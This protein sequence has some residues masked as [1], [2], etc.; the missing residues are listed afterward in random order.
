[1]PRAHVPDVLRGRVFRGRDAVAAGLLTPDALRS[2][3]WRRL[4]R[5][6]YADAE[7]PDTFGVRIRGA[8][9]VVPAAAV[10]SGRTAAY[11]HGATELVDVRTPVEVSIPADARF[12]PVAGL[13]VRRLVLTT[14]DVVVVRSRRCTTS[15]RTALDI[16]RAEPLVEG[17]AALDVLLSRGVVGHPQLRAAVTAQPTPR[18]AR[19]AEQ[20]VELA[21]VR[22]ESPQES[23]LRVVLTLAGLA[24]V[25][26]H[27]VRDQ[28][29]R[30][31]ARV[32]LA[33]PEH[34]VAV[35][36][37]GAWHGEPGQLGRDRRRLNALVAAGWTVL[38]VTA[39]DLRHPAELVTRVRT[40]LRRTTA[41]K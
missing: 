36:Y 15:I 28:D 39:A 26:Q 35:E 34:R 41:G 30:F 1:M 8:G 37:D 10:F 32:D 27:T 21:D 25:P 31:V 7:L 19:R 17:V 22:A 6:I 40:L 14:S 9:L 20:A 38:H 4:Y 29:G 23:R 5:G 16:A 33:F 12:G 3:A 2:S 13:H 24:A 18:G 11:L